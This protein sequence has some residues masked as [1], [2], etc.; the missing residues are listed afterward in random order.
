M[1]KKLYDLLVF[2]A[3]FVLLSDISD[4]KL[5]Y[6]MGFFRIII[7]VFFAIAGSAYYISSHKTPLDSSW[8]GIFDVSLDILIMGCAFL[9]M[10]LLHLWGFVGTDIFSAYPV[11]G[12]SFSTTSWM[13]YFV[14]SLLIRLTVIAE[15]L[16]HWWERRNAKIKLIE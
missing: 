7:P 12:F 3:A 15:K 2:C 1:K 5:C 9:G 10:A 16:F 11:D 6:D 14:I 8:K 13:I 4:T